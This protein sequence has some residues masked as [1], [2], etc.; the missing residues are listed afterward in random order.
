ML[1]RNH[2]EM[3][4]VVHP[5]HG[6]TPDRGP[7]A[8]RIPLAPGSGDRPLIFVSLALPRSIPSRLGVPPPLPCPPNAL[9]ETRR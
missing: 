8:G 5:S 2:A 3:R 7:M 6:A 1:H 9:P 4:D